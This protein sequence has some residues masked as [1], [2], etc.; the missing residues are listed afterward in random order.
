[1]GFRHRVLAGSVFVSHRA[2]FSIE[3]AMDSSEILHK[4]P[5]NVGTKT[6]KNVT[7]HPKASPEN[8]AESIFLCPVIQN[9]NLGRNFRIR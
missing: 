9:F 5:L 8:D 4:F 6:S 7:G 2:A 1:M 3:D